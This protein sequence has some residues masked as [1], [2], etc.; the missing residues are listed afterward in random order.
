MGDRTGCTLE[1]RSVDAGVDVL[2]ALV[3]CVEPEWEPPCDESWEEWASRDDVV[4][5]D[6][7]QVAVGSS[8]EMAQ[9]M[10]E[11]MA[12]RGVET[13]WRVWE[14]PAY[15]WL[16]EVWCYEPSVGLFR[17]EC[18]ASGHPVVYAQQIEELIGKTQGRDELVQELR[19]VTGAG[20]GMG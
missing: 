8:G 15:E 14:D 13:W 11:V 18:D 4:R 2:Q 17:A 3:A 19:R 9:A 5:V 1:V 7:P 16:G 10:V 6:V 20:M 12:E